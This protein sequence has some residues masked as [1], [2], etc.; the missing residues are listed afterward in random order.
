[1][2]TN[3]PMTETTPKTQVESLADGPVIVAPGAPG[4]IIQ[5]VCPESDEAETPA[6]GIEGEETVWEAHYSG[7]NFIGRMAF[8]VL[9]ICAWTVII[10]YNWSKAAGNQA[11]GWPFWTILVGLIAIGYWVNL[12][13]RYL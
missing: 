11:S 12:G 6:P 7:R 8:G 3:E 4:A 13:Y 9:L 10:L 5:P 2:L 1:M